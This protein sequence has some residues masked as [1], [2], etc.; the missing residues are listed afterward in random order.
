MNTGIMQILA[1]C[2]TMVPLTWKRILKNDPII[3]S[4][5]TLLLRW[6]MWPYGCF[7]CLKKLIYCHLLI[8]ISIHFYLEFIMV[9]KFL[10]ILNMFLNDCSD[11]SYYAEGKYKTQILMLT[12][13]SSFFYTSFY[14]D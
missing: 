14:T 3:L 11:K 12:I 2:T 10:S 7:N 4:S 9:S 8:I 5:L 6:T 1:C 13:F